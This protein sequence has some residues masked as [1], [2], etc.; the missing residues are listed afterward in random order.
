MSSMRSKIFLSIIATLLF[1]IFLCGFLFYIARTGS[2]ELQEITNKTFEVIRQSEALRQKFKDMDELTQRVLTMSNFVTKEEIRQ[3]FEFNHTA[4]TNAG[5]GLLQH[6]VS[7]TM[8]KKVIEFNK[9]KNIWLR[10]SR[11]LLGLETSDSI[12]IF[13]V[14]KIKQAKLETSINELVKLAKEEATS[15]LI[16]TEK[17]LNDTLVNTFSV[18]LAIS[19]FFTLLAFFL[20]RGLSKPLVSLV[21]TAKDLAS[22][23]T[24]VKF[25]QSQRQDEIG[26]VVRAVAGFRDG[27]IDRLKLQEDLKTQAEE[28]K[29]AL[30]KEKELN[31]L[32]R[33]F[34]SMVSHEFRTPLAIIDA[35][36]RRLDKRKEKASS[37][38]IDK[39]TTKIKNAVHR[40]LNLIEDTLLVAKVDNGKLSI[41]PKDMNLQDL[42]E[43]CCEN[44]NEI[45][46]SHYISYNLDNL[47][48]NFVGDKGALTQVITN[49]LSNAVKYSPDCFAIEVDGWVEGS[50][51]LISVR[52]YGLGMDEEDVTQLFNRF[53]RAK[54]STGIPGTG[55]GLNLVRTLVE[56]HDGEI[57]VT[58]EQGEGSTFTVRL[59][60]KCEIPESLDLAS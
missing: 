28:L 53:F 9:R 17:N 50:D 14:Y 39:R 41:S 24:E 57:S 29:E 6:S 35:S 59:P 52:D 26:E 7:E 56:K 12:P 42:I 2:N 54:T 30:S 40:M 45:A 25:T 8:H 13:E 34:V 18:M 20:A 58:S 49:L 44:Q 51:V 55:I 27:V 36:A 1:G 47:P 19:V 10:D 48:Q 16:Q 23:N 38:D 32:Q 43:Q 31:E 22:G 3:Q 46:T 5:D 11:L 4:L 21:H 37:E 15:N 60:M 33:Q